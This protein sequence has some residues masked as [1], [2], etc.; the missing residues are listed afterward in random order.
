MSLSLLLTADVHLGL[1]F[2]EYPAIQSELTQARFETLK[3]LV[4]LANA[5]NCDL[6]V[7]AGDLF[8]HHRVADK[9]IVLCKQLLAEFQGKACLVLPGNHDFYAPDNRL[10]TKFKQLP[11][12]R[13][14]VLEEKK[15]YPLRHYDL[16]AC[17]YAAPCDAKRSKTNSTDWV[18][19]ADKDETVKHHIGIAHGSLNGV[20][21]DP[22]GNYFPMS[23]SVL[24]NSGMH[25]WLMGHTDRLQ[26]PATVGLSNMVFYPGTH[27]PN[28]LNCTHEGKA[29]LL[30]LDDEN[31]I[32]AESIACGKYRFVD[33]TADIT[34]YADMEALIQ[35]FGDASAQT[36]ILRLVLRGSL[37]KSDFDKSNDFETALKKNLFYVEVDLSGLQPEI[38]EEMID[39]EF[40]KDSFP[41][42]LLKTM[43]KDPA[44]RRALQL[45]YDLIKE[46]KK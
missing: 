45:A 25:L 41:F 43:A 16:D 19:T 26:Y 22:E 23:E 1:K 4:D 42:R 38:T 31:K 35:K 11:G 28:G 12:D 37:P 9:D 17:I 29:W 2:S 10:W 20:S 44:D 36:T 14:I 24:A 30:N 8:D 21:P 27:E 7:V 5:R 13:V 39:A 46:V 34:G 32:T 18:A 40:T 33:E 6:F 15:M 3:K